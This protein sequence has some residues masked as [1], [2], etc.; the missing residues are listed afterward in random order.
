VDPVTLI[1]G[2]LA[3][4]ALKGTGE[5][6]STVI[7]D[8]YAALKAAVAARF[9]EKQV[10]T[11]VLAEHEDDPETYEK[12]LAK[13]IQQ[14]GAAEDPRIVELAQAL[15]QL[16]DEDGTRAGKYLVD[17]RGAQGVQVGDRNTQTNTFGAATPPA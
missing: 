11:G 8:T 7:K 2:A 3:A 9:V 6:A 5:T 1:V 4:G 17:L 13:K 14:T 15:V 12:P 10:P 16:M